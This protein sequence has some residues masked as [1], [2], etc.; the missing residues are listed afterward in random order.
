[1]K[2]TRRGS[3]CFARQVHR[4]AGAC[5]G[6]EPLAGHRARLAA[7]LAPIALMRWPFDGPVAWREQHGERTWWHVAEDWCY[8]GCAGTLEEAQALAGAPARFDL[9]TYQI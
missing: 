9:D 4:C 6:A 5:I 1:E 7:A 8:L 3:P 2:T